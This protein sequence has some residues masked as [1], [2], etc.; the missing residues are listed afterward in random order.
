[1]TCDRGIQEIFEYTLENGATI[2]ATKD[3]EFMTSNGQMLPIDEI[4]EQGL[5]LLELGAKEV[6]ELEFS[7]MS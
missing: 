6:T 2:K 7:F 5:D 3:H 1:M 4:F